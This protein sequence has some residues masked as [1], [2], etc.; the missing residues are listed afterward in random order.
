MY[1]LIS[2]QTSPYGRKVRI[3][4]EV[5]GL[6]KNFHIQTANTLDP[7][8]P[9]RQPNPLGKMPAL[10]P[11]H[12]TPIFDSRV[13]IDYLESRF[14]DGQLIPID[15]EHRTRILTLAALAEGITDALLLIVYEDRYR[16]P[17]QASQIWLDHQCGKIVRGLQSAT[18]QIGEFKAPNIAA[19]T[20]ACALG[21][22]DWRKQ[23]DWRTEFPRL[24]VWLD[25]FAN[26]V[27][28]WGLTR[29]Q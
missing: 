16:Q 15:P 11:E 22:A 12:G 19:I 6:G 28:A 3:A 23:I 18:R 20:L 24:E 14:G 26:A 29:A 21:Y 5:L 27:P 10:V 13:I 9:I 7:D 25:D 2:S 4:I 17:E 8:D 1:T